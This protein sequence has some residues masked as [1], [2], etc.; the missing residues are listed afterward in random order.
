MK[1]MLKSCLCLLVSP[2]KRDITLAMIA[3]DSS[4]YKI[5]VN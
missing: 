4:C 2:T 5:N 1:S 3:D